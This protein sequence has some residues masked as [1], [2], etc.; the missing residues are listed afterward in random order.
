MTSTCKSVNEFS[1]LRSAVNDVSKTAHCSVVFAWVG[2]I[3]VHSNEKNRSGF[4]DSQGFSTRVSV[5]EG[6]K[7]METAPPGERLPVMTRFLAPVAFTPA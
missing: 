6:S 4:I 5:Q 2:R 7:A 1:Y 3:K